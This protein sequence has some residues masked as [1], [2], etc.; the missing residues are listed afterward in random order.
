MYAAL[1]RVW[2]CRST[3]SLSGRSRAEAGRVGNG[4]LWDRLW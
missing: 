3:S 4:G 1:M 2:T